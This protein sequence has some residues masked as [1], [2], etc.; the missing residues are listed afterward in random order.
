MGTQ[1]KFEN[2]Y[3]APAVADILEA[4]WDPDHLA[5]QDKLA[6]LCDREVVEDTETEGMRKTVWKV[7]STRPIPMIAKPF[8]SGGRLTYLESMIRRGDNLVESVV[9]PQ[10]LKGRVH[11]D[12]TYQLEKVGDNQVRRTYAGTIHAN[13]TLVGGRIE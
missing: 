9:T 2:I 1:F 3:R 11:L 10:I 12:S 7:A 5:T 13:I 4:Y 8:V 6:N